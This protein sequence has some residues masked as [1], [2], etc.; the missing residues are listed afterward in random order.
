MGNDFSKGSILKLIIA[1]AV[2]LTIA[3]LV[4]VLYNIIDRIFIGHIPGA[5]GMALTGIGLAFPVITIISAFT[6]LFGVGG[7]P[8]FSM[9]RGRG[10]ENRAFQ[11]MNHSAFMLLVGG[12]LINIFF[13]I[14]RKELIMAFGGSIDT[15]SYADEYLRIY[16]FGTIFTMFSTGM[17]G[18]ISA[19]GF[20]RMGMITVVIGAVINTILDYLLIIVFNMGIAGA[21][22]ATIIAQFI[23]ALWVFLFLTGNKT[24]I[25]LSLKGFVLDF[26]TCGSIISL[27]VANSIVYVSNALVQIVCNN[28]LKIY[29]GDVFIGVMT[30]LNSVREIF[31]IATQG[32]MNGTQPITSFNYGA[33]QYKRVKQCIKDSVLLGSAYTMI[34][35]IIILLIPQ[36]VIQIFNNDPEMLMYG[37]EALKIYFFGFIFM[38]FQFGGQSTFTALGKSKYAIFFSLF[39]KAIIVLPLT[40]FLPMIGNL[41]V[42][43]VFLAEPISNVVGGLASFITMIITVWR[44]LDV[45]DS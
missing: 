14:F 6:A 23:S 33:K 32:I 8:L 21:A 40:I 30:I 37:T 10:E 31:G 22:I 25:K 36:T 2:P 38:A 39:R 12:V 5:S 11:I 9:A 19:Q 41:G 35:W 44:K 20:P 26:K 4:Q 42:W 16:L 27:G 17:N 13:F 15:I 18:Y 29:G 24:L 3:Q 34:V 7:V 1:Q 43:G 45:Q 28:T